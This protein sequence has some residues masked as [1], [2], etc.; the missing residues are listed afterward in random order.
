MGVADCESY[1]TRI[2]DPSK[3]RTKGSNTIRSNTI[4]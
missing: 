4:P 2:L 3:T 1:L